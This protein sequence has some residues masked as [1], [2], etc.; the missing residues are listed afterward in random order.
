VVSL[1][2]VLLADGLRG[3][4]EILLGDVS[5]SA[6]H[7]RGSLIADEQVSAACRRW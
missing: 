1:T 5:R 7:N 6:M 4:R 3:W 2:L